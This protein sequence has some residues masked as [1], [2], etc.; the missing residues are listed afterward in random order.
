MAQRLGRP[1]TSGRRPVRAAHRYV[2]RRGH[3]RRRGRPAGPP[4][5]ARR[6]PCVADAGLPVPRHP[7]VGVRGGVALGRARAVRGAGGAQALRRHGARSRARGPPGRGPQPPRP[8]RQSSPGLRPVLHRDPSHAVGC[9]GQPRRPRFGRGAGVPA[10]QRARLAAGLPA[11]RA[12]ARRGP[13]PGRRAG[14]DL[15]G[16]AVHGGRRARGR[17][18]PSAPA[19][20]RVRPL[21]PA[22]H[23]PRE[24]GGIGLHAQWN[25]DFHHALHTALTGESQGY[26]ADFAGLRWPPSPRP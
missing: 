4:R 26:Y 2:H 17:A 5:R 21:R 20:R 12:A 10:G 22:D 14:A 13:R 7:R 1:G 16:G 6:H 23:D 3:L 9:G 11:R 19:D 25:D 15:P 24:S 8:V 18:G